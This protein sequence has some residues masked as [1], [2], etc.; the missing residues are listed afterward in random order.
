MQ[1]CEFC[2]IEADQIQPT[3]SVILISAL[4]STKV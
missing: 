4:Y 2:I 1:V 3:K